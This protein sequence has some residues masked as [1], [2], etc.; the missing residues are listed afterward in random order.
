MIRFLSRLFA[1]LAA[2]F[3]PASLPGQAAMPGGHDLPRIVPNDNREPAGQLEEGVLTLR[4]TAGEGM[5]HPHG[6]DRP[7][8]RIGAFAEDGGPLEIPGPL[9]RV[10]AGTEV[11]TTVHNGLDKPLAVF[12]LGAEH[13]VSGDSV[14]VEP[15]GE[16][17][18]AFVASEPGR[19]SFST[20]SGGRSTPKRGKSK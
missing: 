2:L 15:D 4:L 5:W 12:G 3:V 6:F 20:S 13:G 14:L 16:A 11:R 18:F 7:G 17:E 8:I 1:V 9:I 10:P 19:P